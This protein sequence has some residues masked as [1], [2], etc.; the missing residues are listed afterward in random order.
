MA[1]NI[2]ELHL[3]Y[4]EWEQQENEKPKQKEAF[5]CY[6]A[7]GGSIRH[8][9]KELQGH[10]KGDIFHGVK[11]L[12]KPFSEDTFRQLA[13][14]H[15]F[16][17]RRDQKMNYDIQRRNVQFDKI[18]DETIISK[19]QK[20][21]DSEVATA[22]LLENK[23]KSGT[24][25]GTQA[26]DFTIALNNYQEYKKKLRGEDDT[27]RVLLDATVD[28]EIDAKKENY[29][30]VGELSDYNLDDV[31]SEVTEDVDGKDTSDNG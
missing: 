26:K 1:T 15:K 24:I 6:C 31:L 18:E 21:D 28:A 25:N 10:Q 11:L 16:K 22:N 23:I 14:A 7:H 5:D 29:L 12:Y 4:P 30:F 9:A 19:Y 17:Y 13:S 27:K 3:E 8:C 20:A 2:H